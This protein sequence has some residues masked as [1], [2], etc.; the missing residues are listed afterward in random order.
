MSKQ[1]FCIKLVQAVEKY[2][3]LHNY[4]LSDY[5]RKDIVDK[6]WVEIGKEVNEVFF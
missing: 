1:D 5:S 4:K 2:P 6:A 3:C